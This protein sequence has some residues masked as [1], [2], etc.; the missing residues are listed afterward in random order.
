MSF[1]PAHDDR[2]P[3]GVAP[4][5]E[6]TVAQSLYGFTEAHKRDGTTPDPWTMISLLS[7]YIVE[8]EEKMVHMQKRLIELHGEY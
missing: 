8:L 2:R 5:D 7:G 1:W 3:A 4:T 6:Y